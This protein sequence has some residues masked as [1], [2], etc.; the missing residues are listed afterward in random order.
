MQRA[1]LNREN[2]LNYMV[3]NLFDHPN[4]ITSIIIDDCLGE[5]RKSSLFFL[6]SFQKFKEKFMIN[7]NLL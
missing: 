5:F 4:N 7:M 1:F 6:Y 2:H 3:E